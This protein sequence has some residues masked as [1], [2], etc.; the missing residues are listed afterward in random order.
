MPSAGV[1][2]R[3]LRRMFPSQYDEGASELVAPKA[4]QHWPGYACLADVLADYHRK[5]GERH[6]FNRKKIL[7]T[8]DSGN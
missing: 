1:A 3:L 4:L 8:V 5:P 6:F 2:W 7:T